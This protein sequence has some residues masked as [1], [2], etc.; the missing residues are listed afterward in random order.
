[1]QISD[2]AKLYRKANQERAVMGEKMCR[3][4]NVLQSVLPRFM[5]IAAIVLIVKR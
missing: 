4:R 3:I 2:Y 1:M 5:M